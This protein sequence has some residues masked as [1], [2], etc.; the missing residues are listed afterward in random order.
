MDYKGYRHIPR[1]LFD[2]ITFLA[3]HRWV[4]ILS[5]SYAI[6]QILVLLNDKKILRLASFSPWRRN[7]P[8]TAGRVRQGLCYY[9]GYVNIRAMWHP[10]SGIFGPHIWPIEDEDHPK[11]SKAA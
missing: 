1:A 6:P 8:I 5:V 2:A 4:Q 10:K 11:P 3:L 9:F 7:Q